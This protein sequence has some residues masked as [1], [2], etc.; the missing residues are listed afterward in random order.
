MASTASAS[1]RYANEVT[2]VVTKTLCVI[3]SLMSTL[4][5]AAVLVST[6]L[7]ALVFKDLFPNDH[8]IAISHGKRRP[9]K[10]CLSL[11]YTSH[12]SIEIDLEAST[13][14]PNGREINS[15]SI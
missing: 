6:I 15:H 13:P 5:I 3:L 8:A 10:K 4:I 14:L 7:H 12:D 2:N 11:G 1:V 9:E